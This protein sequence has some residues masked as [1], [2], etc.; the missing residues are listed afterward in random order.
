M[1]TNSPGSRSRTK[2]ASIR[3]KAHVSDARTQASPSR[4]RDRGRNPCG[5]RVPRSAAAWIGPARLVV[6]ELG[7]AGRRIA[8]VANGQRALEAAEADLAEDIRHEAH[9]PL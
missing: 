7:A 3:S 9:P 1:W 2:V 6:L 5:S 8:H 4:P